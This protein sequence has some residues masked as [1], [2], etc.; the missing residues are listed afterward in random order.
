MFYYI[1]FKI[2]LR[3]KN[4]LNLIYHLLLYI[5]TLFNRFHSIKRAYKYVLSLLEEDDDEPALLI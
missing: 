4:K 1:F 5:I 2:K 3:I